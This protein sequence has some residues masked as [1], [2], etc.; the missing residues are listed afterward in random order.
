[1]VPGW[2]RFKAAQDWLDAKA[3]KPTVQTP[4]QP[5]ADFVRFLDRAGKRDLAPEE[6]ERLYQQF[7][8]WSKK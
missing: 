7:L 4:T 1:V 8:E 6:K 3:V 5:Q 2:T